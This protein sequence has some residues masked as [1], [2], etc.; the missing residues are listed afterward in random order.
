MTVVGQTFPSR[1][2]RHFGAYKYLLLL[3]Y[4]QMMYGVLLIA[5]AYS[6]PYVLTTCSRKYQSSL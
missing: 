3:R 2:D 1:R 5:R 4:V 6:D